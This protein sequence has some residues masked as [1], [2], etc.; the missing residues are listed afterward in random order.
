[1]ANNKCAHGPCKC[2][3][4]EIRK[5]GYCSDSC[6]QGNAANGRCACGHPACR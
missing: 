2:T 5:D 6:K 3:G 1:M 4:G